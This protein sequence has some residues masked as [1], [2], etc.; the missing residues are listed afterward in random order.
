MISMMRFKELVMTMPAANLKIL[1][2]A[3]KDNVKANFLTLC[4]LH[5]PYLKQDEILPFFEFLKNEV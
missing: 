1:K 2:A 5:A 3:A 4:M